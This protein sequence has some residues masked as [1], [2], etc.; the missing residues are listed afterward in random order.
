[1]K[2]LNRRLIKSSKEVIIELLHLDN[3][4][5]IVYNTTLNNGV[6]YSNMYYV[7]GFDKVGNPIYNTDGMSLGSR[8]SENLKKSS[9]EILENFHNRMQN[10]DRYKSIFEILKTLI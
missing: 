7:E 5:T 8:E 6:V 3:D 2:I 9:F 1:M 4:I 10:K